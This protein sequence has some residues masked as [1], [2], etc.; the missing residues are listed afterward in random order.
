M[1]YW[2][3]VMQDDVYGIAAEGWQAETYRVLVKDKKGK[4][5]DKGWACDLVPKELIHGSLLCGPAIG[6]RKTQ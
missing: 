4:E 2:A 6:D 1:D 5:K 3:E